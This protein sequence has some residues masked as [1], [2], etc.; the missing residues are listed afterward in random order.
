MRVDQEW[1]IA[2]FVVYNSRRCEGWRKGQ[3]GDRRSTSHRIEGGRK[4]DLLEGR[5]AAR[6]S[7]QLAEH[8]VVEDAVTRTD[9]SFALLKR[10]PRQ[11]DARLEVVPVVVVKRRQPMLPIPCDCEREGR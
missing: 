1:E 9:G 11:P 8:P 3:R 10:I 5:I 2:C 6:K 4:K 7:E